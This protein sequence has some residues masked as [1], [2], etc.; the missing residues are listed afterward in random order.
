MNLDKGPEAKM[1]ET[2]IPASFSA[3]VMSIAST[4]AMSMGVEI[5]GAPNTLDKNLIMAK[6]NI[7]LLKMLAGKTKGNL[8]TEEQEFLRAVINDLQL[9]FVEV[10]NEEG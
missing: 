1:K 2:E 10:S 8:D 4:S 7:D 6:F 9:K 3:L 5:E